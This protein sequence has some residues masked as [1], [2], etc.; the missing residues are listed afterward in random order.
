MATMGAT[1][2]SLF[3]LLAGLLPAG[4]TSLV[5][6][7]PR[8][9]RTEV[10]RLGGFNMPECVLPEAA[11][12]GFHVS[13]IE[14]TPT[15]AWA[16]D[17]LGFI[18]RYSLDRQG[19]E[20]WVNSSPAAVLNSPKGMCLLGGRLYFADNSRLLACDAQTGAGLTVVASGF[21][22][23]NDLATDGKDVW[24]SDSAAE[25][26]GQVWCV[27]PDG[28]TKRQVPAPRRVNGLTFHQG[29]LFAVSWDWHD[30]YE[31]DAR[32]ELPPVPF[33]QAHHFTNLDGIE[34]L[35]DGTFIVSDFVGNQLC[36]ISPDRRRVKVLAQVPSPADI[37]LDRRR[38]LLYVPL[39]LDHQV[40][41]FAI[42]P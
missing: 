24:L 1:V 11:T 19:S 29:R 21:V 23:A 18:S 9:R 26:G 10:A 36:A 41:V 35:D 20:R 6:W 4:C 15:T 38:G 32:G 37:G 22:N 5:P 17:G 14:A 27:A 30:V 12:G 33:G 34:V 31:L 7:G 42:R 39:L 28:S 3:L 8:V 16:D 25:H 13:N 40:V 2:R